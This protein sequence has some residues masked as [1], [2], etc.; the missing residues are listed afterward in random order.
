MGRDRIRANL[1]GVDRS[2]ANFVRNGATGLRDIP[3][4]AV[5]GGDGQGER[6]IV[7][8]QALGTFDRANDRLAESGAIA[9]HLKANLV[10]LQLF[11]FA[12][13]R[14]EKQIEQHPHLV[15]G[16]PPVFTRK[17]K[18]REIFNAS[19]TCRFDQFA[20]ALLALAM[21]GDTRQPAALGP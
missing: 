2:G 5:I 15:L 16:A 7:A 8:R 4:S 21:S 11:E 17:R 12:I 13:E 18:Q 1:R 14:R 6:G 19:S 10:L 9:R 3:T 20:Y